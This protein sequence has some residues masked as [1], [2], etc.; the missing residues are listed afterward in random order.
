MDARV[1]NYLR[2]GRFYVEG[3]LRTE[4]ALT[5]IALADR[6]RALGVN[7]GTAEI[8]V[9]HGKLFILLYLLSRSPERAV[10]VD[11]FDDQHL[12]ID[13][14]GAGDLARFRHN[15]ERHAGSDRLVLKPGNSLALCGADL[16]RLADGPLRLA[17]VDGGH[18][19]EI[20]AHDL[21]T[22]EAAL[23]EG[24]IVIVD[25]VFNEQWPGVGD[26]VRRWFERR[27]NLVPFAIGANKTYFCRPSHRDVYRQAAVAAAGAATTTEFLGE[28]VAFLQFARPGFKDRL[29]ASPL[30]RQVRTT[31]VGLP[32]RWAWHTG[33]RLRRGL[34]RRE[35]F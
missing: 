24:G 30:W 7:G 29:A 17:S 4:A 23:A 19:A 8:G 26:G 2:R 15:L 32:L 34:A 21:A 27:P 9:H 33:R 13:Q 11:L 12:N 14:S 18:T 3:W 10:A 22:V 35:D 1:E 5:V 31:P 20:A 28:A 25:D 6:Q 16:V